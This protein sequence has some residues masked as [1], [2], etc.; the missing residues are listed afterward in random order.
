[1][2]TAFRIFLPVLII[3]ILFAFAACAGDTYDN[4]M[5]N[6]SVNDS[7]A[8]VAALAVSIEEINHQ[9]VLTGPTGILTYSITGGGKLSASVAAGTW[10]VD[11]TGYYGEE[12]FS[13]GT[14]TVTVIPGQINSVSVNM[15]VVWQGGGLLPPPGTELPQLPGKAWIDGENGF[16]VTFGFEISAIYEDPTWD[17]DY[18][19]TRSPYDG[20]I[21]E[22]Y[23]GGRLVQTDIDVVFYGLTGPSTYGPVPLTLAFKVEDEYW[24]RDVFIIVRHPEYYGVRSN[25]LRICKEITASDWLSFSA[26]TGA[27]EWEGN[28]FIIQ[29]IPTPP[30]TLDRPD[31]PFGSSSKPF[32]GYFDGNGVEINFGPL[33]NLPAPPLEYAGLFARIGPHG[34]VINLKLGKETIKNVYTGANTYIGKVAGINEGTIMNVE[35]IEPDIP[36]P[37]PV[38]GNSSSPFPL[39]PLDLSYVGGIVGYNKGIIKNCYVRS[40]LLFFAGTDAGGNGTS[41]T[42]GIAGLNEGEISYCWVNFNL[43]TGTQA[44]TAA[45]GIAGKNSKTIDHCVVLGGS[46]E[47]MVGRYG[48]GRIWGTGNGI[49]RANYANNRNGSV[50]QLFH[51]GTNQFYVDRTDDREDSK[52]GKGV[53]YNSGTMYVTDDAGSINWWLYTAD[54]DKVWDQTD[55]NMVELEKPWKGES[56]FLWPVLWWTP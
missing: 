40:D 18:L 23:L 10:R 43:G 24:N 53:P 30:I 36:Y 12:I 19:E 22:W 41:C 46:F 28:S 47:N 1:M 42:G 16:S 27:W 32:N 31:I 17:P 37:I 8:R 29:A 3:F 52:H 2:K 13:E 21:V 56:S 51:D 33:M 7:R 44:R 9:I 4:A 50:I 25:S 35:Y 55:G 54:W 48:A 45:G 20:Y 26:G 14:A 38:F 39:F 49:G 5:L 34:A 15:A 11:V 6:I